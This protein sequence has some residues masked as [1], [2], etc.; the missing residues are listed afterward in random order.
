MGK[1]QWSRDAVHGSFVVLVGPDGVGKT[2]IARAIIEQAPDTLYFH[3]RPP[4]STP[5]VVP[6]PGQVLPKPHR[7]TGAATSV[8]RLVLAMTRFW[9]SYLAHIRPE[10]RRG[11]TVLGDRWAYGYVARPRELRYQGPEGL[12]RLFLRLLPQPDL[13]V[14]LVAPPETIAG[15]KAE[16][17]IAEI[18]TDLESWRTVAPGKTIEISTVAPIHEVATRILEMIED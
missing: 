16:L 8:A 13:V 1:T 11:T 9:L 14:C 2:S 15:R 7:A 18:E 10:L 6:E 12:A 3:F 5:W 17:S 4:L